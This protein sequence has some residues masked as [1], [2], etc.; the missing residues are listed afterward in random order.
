MDLVW[1]YEGDGTPEWKK[2]FGLAHILAKHPW[3]KGHLQEMLDRM[4]KATPRGPERV[5]LSNEQGE[6]A[7]LALTWFGRE[8]KTW[9]LTEYDPGKPGPERILDGSGSP[10]SGAGE[11]TS[12]PPGSTSSLTAGAPG[13]NIPAPKGGA[14]HIGSSLEAVYGETRMKRPA[15]FSIRSSASLA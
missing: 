11:P 10:V 15:H 14:P 12:P 1:G 2:G 5:D 8:N 7:V 3:L 6:H 9:L 13:D 4:T